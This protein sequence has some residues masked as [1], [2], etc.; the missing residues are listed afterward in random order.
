MKRLKQG[1]MTL[2]EF[3]SEVSKSLNFA[4]TKA[5]MDSSENPSAMKEYANQEAVR[6]LILDLNSKYTSGTLYSHNIAS[7]IY[8]DNMNSQ[9]DV[10]QYNQHRQHNTSQYQYTS[11]RHHEE[12]QRY[13]PNVQVRY[14]QTAP[15][16]QHQPMDVDS[17][18][19]YMRS[20]NYNRNHPAPQPNSYDRKTQ[21]LPPNNPFRGDPQKRE[22][23]P[24]SRNIPQEVQRVNQTCDEELTSLVP[25][26]ENE[27]Y[28]TGSA[29]LGA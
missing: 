23:N 6:T 2:A 29:F 8:H 16:Q 17:L 7:T 4:L 3:H 27:E 26:Y 15:S 25:E 22:R 19:Q 14:N 20:T 5:E 28:E 24:S 13:K 12:P 1:K 11:R 21:G 10:P 9:F 18:Q